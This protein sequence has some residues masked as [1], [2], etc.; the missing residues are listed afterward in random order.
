MSL[1]FGILGLLAEDPLHGY[2]VKQR[3]EE[4]LGGTWELNIGSVYQ[5]LLRLERDGLV[6]TTGDRGDRGRQAY[7]ATEAGASALEEWLEDP[8]SQPQLLREDLYVKLLLLGR[9]ANGRLERL[10]NRQRH[11]QLQRMRDLAE[12][13]KAAREGGRIQLALLFKGGQ[14][15]T[16]ADLKFLDAV[17]E[18]MESD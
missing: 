13:E 18:E 1:R 9:Q 2:Q 17:V 8:E 15:H 12:Q 10:L 14:L 16:E 7:R 6:E 3:F 5:A 4:M 11:V